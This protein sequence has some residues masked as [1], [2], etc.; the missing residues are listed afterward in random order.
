MTKQP[1]PFGPD[2]GFGLYAHWPYCARICP[3]CD[4]NVYTAKTRDTGDLFAAM[5]HDLTAQAATLPDHPPL[6]SIFLG[7]GT[8]SLMQPRQIEHLIKACD[9]A[10]GLSNACEIT[11]EANPN[12]V[13]AASAREWHKAGINRL[14][15]SLIHI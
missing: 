14:S 1:F 13:T 11:L 15:L 2:Y 3:Y 9:E 12:N 5:L 4:F 7:G 10:F 8:P 6:T